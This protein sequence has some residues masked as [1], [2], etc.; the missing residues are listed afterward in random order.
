MDKK[1]RLWSDKFPELHGDPH[2][3]AGFLHGREIACARQRGERV[4]PN[5]I[6]DQVLTNLQFS[7]GYVDGHVRDPGGAS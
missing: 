1:V 3:R 6:D 5:Q 7:R 4:L 2:Y